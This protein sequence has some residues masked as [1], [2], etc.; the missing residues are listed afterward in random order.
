MYQKIS[1]WAAR[2]A[3]RVPRQPEPRRGRRRRVPPLGARRARRRRPGR[4]PR[5]RRGRRRSRTSSRRRPRFAVIFAAG[6]AEVGAEGETLQARLEELVAASD[7]AP[8]RAR[9]P[10]ST[11]SR[12]SATTSRAAPS[13]SSP[14]A[15]TRAGPIFQAPGAR[16]PRSRTG[17]RPATRSTS[18]SPTSPATSPTSPR[19]ASI[20]GY[21][22]GFKDGRTLH[23]GRRPRGAAAACRSCA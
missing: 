9:T 7:T 1:A 23:A 5:R 21:I 20:A 15:A 17:R 11:R 14:R 22:E 19:S 4:D 10:T 12:R 16:H 18:S 13:R 2:P 8:A 3:P 6:F